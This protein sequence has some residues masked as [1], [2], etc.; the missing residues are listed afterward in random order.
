MLDLELDF[1]DIISKHVCININEMISSSELLDLFGKLDDGMMNTFFQ[2]LNEQD[3]EIM[4]H[5][6]E[7]LAKRNNLNELNQDFNFQFVTDLLLTSKFKLLGQK[8][9]GKVY[10]AIKQ[11]NLHLFKAYYTDP[12][13]IEQERGYYESYLQYALIFKSKNIIR[14]LLDSNYSINEIN[15]TGLTSTHYALKYGDVEIIKLFENHNA[16][17]FVLSRLN[18]TPVDFSFMNSDLNSLEYLFINEYYDKLNFYENSRFVHS[19]DSN[20][21]IF[22]L[23]KLLLDKDVLNVHDMI[24][25]NT[26]IL[27]AILMN[28]RTDLLD[29][30]FAKYCDIE[31]DVHIGNTP[32]NFAV[33]LD[34]IE[35]VK[36]LLNKGANV[37]S[38]SDSGRSVL[39]NSV[40]WSNYDMFKLLIQH[41]ADITLDDK[42]V[43][44]NA[45][46][47]NKIDVLKFMVENDFNLNQKLMNNTS[48]QNAIISNRDEITNYIIDKSDVDYFN[49]NKIPILID[50]TAKSSE[51]I[52]KRLLC[53]GFDPNINYKGHSP[54]TNAISMKLSTYIIKE[55]IVRDANLNFRD[56]F[57]R[58]PTHLAI[59]SN[60]LDVVKLIKEYGGAINTRMNLFYSSI[61]LARK[62]GFY[63]IEAYLKRDKHTR[64]GL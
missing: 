34:N 21:Q 28:N 54:L 48:L 35:L 9:N 26:S 10:E 24:L 51:E 33:C 47:H 19:L 62:N 45:I 56:K 38:F 18:E 8:N 55:F 46:Y 52:I 27:A 29:H 15:E 60:N 49:Q 61:K 17:F 44:A 6:H 42:M 59:L 25:E 37:N 14:L 31:T 36:F 20:P 58:T 50:A 43:V 22:S 39:R 11:D 23:I 64:N 41:G 12:N 63:E 30:V 16:N 40:S 32:L 3:N 1:R 4:N 2:L 5:L 13:D 53:L 57:K 7:V